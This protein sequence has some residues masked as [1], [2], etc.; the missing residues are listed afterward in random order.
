MIDEVF[1]RSG[2]SMRADIVRAGHQETAYDKATIGGVVDRLEQK[3]FVKRAISKADR[4]ARKVWLTE[5]GR[6]IYEDTLPIVADLQMEILS[7]LEAEER[8]QFLLLAQK[9]IGAASG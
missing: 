2:F 5:H 7:G 6:K 8:D 1:G 4:R 3:G 9:A